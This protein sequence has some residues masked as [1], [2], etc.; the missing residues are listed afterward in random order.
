VRPAGLVRDL[1]VAGLSFAFS[2][3]LIAGAGYAAVYQGALFL[4][5]GIPVYVWLRGRQETPEDADTVA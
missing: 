2:F 5:A 1:I 3:W 4:F